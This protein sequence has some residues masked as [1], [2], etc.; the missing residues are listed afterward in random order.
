RQDL[1]ASDAHGNPDPLAVASARRLYGYVSW[2]PF[3]ILGMLDA[4]VVDGLREV[5]LPVQQSHRY[6]IGPLVAC[7]FA[8][9]A[10]Q[11]AQTTRVDR[12]TLMKAVLGTEVRDQGLVRGRCGS[13][14]IGI[15]GI[16]RQH[17]ARGID[18]VL[19]GT[20][21][22]PLADAAKHETGIAACLF[23]QLR[24]EILE[25]RPGRPG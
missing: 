24:V 21:Q 7:S 22:R 3:T 5:P 4:V 6:E 20:V 19:R 1:A 2:V 17:V 13:R 25:Q 8:V 10:G 12:E 14:E 18:R 16:E 15:E 23:P 11:D 9:V